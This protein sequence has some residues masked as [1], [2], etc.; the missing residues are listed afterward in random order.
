LYFLG[1]KNLIVQGSLQANTYVVT[2]NPQEK[3]KLSFVH[4]LS[5]SDASVD[6]QDLLPDIIHQLGQESL[7]KIAE[8]ISGKAAESAEDDDIP[9]LVE[10][11]DDPQ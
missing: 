6:M 7:K 1:L 5:P 2:G 3:S 9:D 11:F 4:F 10:N 8:S